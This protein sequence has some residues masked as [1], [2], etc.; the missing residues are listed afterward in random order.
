MRP[1][2]KL[3]ATVGGSQSAKPR[4]PMHVPLMIS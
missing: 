4:V 3:A 2:V 1:K